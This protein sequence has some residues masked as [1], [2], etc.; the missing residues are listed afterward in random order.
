[1]DLVRPLPESVEAAEAEWL[2]RLARGDLSA[3][4]SLYDRYGRLVYRYALAMVGCEADA[5]D[6]VS[7]VFLRLARQGRRAGR[8]RDLR[9][10]LVRAARNEA[11][12]TLRRRRRQRDALERARLLE[13]AAGDAEA[14]ADREVVEQALAALPGEQRAVVVL[15]VYEGM[16]FAE[17]GRAVGV[18]PNT[19]ASRYR[20][21]IEKLRELLSDDEG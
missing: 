13:P 20:Y 2:R 3:L 17:I 4:G 12:S 18:S 21:G 15:K 7:T 11:I 16:T 9:R 14:E 6:V 1:M 5:E 8:I 10:F 19:A